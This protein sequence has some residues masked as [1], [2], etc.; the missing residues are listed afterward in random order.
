MAERGAILV[1]PTSTSGQL[2]P[3][4][5]W[6]S[7]A[8]WA[9]AVRRVLGDAWLVTIH[10][11]VDPHDARRRG[12][13]PALSSGSTAAWHRGVPVVVKTAIK[14]ARQWQRA[15]RF[16]VDPAGPWQG[17]DVAFVWQRHELFQQAGLRLARRLDVPSVVFVPATLVWEAEQ[18]GVARPGWGSWLERH[19]E[20]PALQAADLVA[21]GSEVVAEQARR[22]GVHADRILVTP[23]GV[24]LEVF[25][26]APDP[27]ERYDLRRRLGLGSRFVAGWVGSF[28]PFHALDLAV[29]AMAGLPDAVLLLVGDGPE[30]A[31]IEALARDRGVDVV[32]AGTIPHAELPAYLATMDVAM[33]VA[34]R[35]RPYH[36]SPLKLAEYLAAGVP[37]VAPKVGQ[38]RERLTDGTEA[39]LVP[40]GDVPALRAALV[41]LQTDTGLRDRLSAAARAAAHQWTWDRQVERIVAALS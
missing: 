31:G 29:E 28:R 37:V 25:G 36:Y 33:V 19:G 26:D 18:W 32:V 13:A 14:D 38:I 34:A 39:I 3:V 10:G 12:S 22:I 8:G 4:A 16:S 24:D 30:R 1:L 15:R 17:H 27:H 6:T 9:S 41:R 40:P 11:I 21:C 35:G 2:G 23:T 7:A 5:A 20:G